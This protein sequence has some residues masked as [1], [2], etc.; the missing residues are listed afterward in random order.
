MITVNELE[1]MV[2]NCGNSEK[3]LKKIADTVYVLAYCNPWLFKLE[4][5]NEDTRSDFLLDMFDYFKKIPL[6]FDDEKGD[7]LNYITTVLHRNFISWIRRVIKKD[8]TEKETG[9]R[10]RRYY[11]KVNQTNIKVYYQ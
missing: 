11:G 3:E 4:R 7:L 8:T 5:M 6:Y 9:R 1:A 2:K 10:W